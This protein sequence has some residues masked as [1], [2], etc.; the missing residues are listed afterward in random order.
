M[1]T[2]IPDVGKVP[3]DVKKLTKLFYDVVTEHGLYS[4]KHIALIDALHE[5]EPRRGRLLWVLAQDKVLNQLL[6]LKR[7]SPIGQGGRLAS[8]TE[9]WLRSLSVEGKELPEDVAEWLR[10]RR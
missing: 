6:G 7:T 10:R 4:R 1:G 8:Q 9:D 2:E 5:Q 3:T